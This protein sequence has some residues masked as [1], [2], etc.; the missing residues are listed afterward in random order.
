[1]ANWNIDSFIFGG[2]RL[3]SSEFATEED[4]YEDKEVMVKR[5]GFWERIFDTDPTLHIWD[6]YR[7][8]IIRVPKRK[9]MAYRIYDT[10]VAHPI[11]IE[12]LTTEF[13][14]F[15]TATREASFSMESFKDT[16]K[17]IEENKW[18]K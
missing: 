10:I 8:V 3:V 15:S 11:I 18:Q 14:K 17:E 4:G 9:P 16:I 13:G 7:P 12:K 5:G 2:T 1:M 6:D